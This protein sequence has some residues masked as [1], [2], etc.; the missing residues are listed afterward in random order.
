MDVEA[1]RALIYYTAEIMDA[2]LPYTKFSSMSKCCGADVAMRVTVNTLPIFGGYGY[3][4]EY[5]MEKMMRDA[6][7]LQIHEG[8]NQVQRS[9]IARELLK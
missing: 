9:V 4:K 5:P 6:K 7:T 2:G 1:A 8:A 3:R